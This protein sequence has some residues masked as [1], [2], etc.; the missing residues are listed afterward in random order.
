MSHVRITAT[1]DGRAFVDR[2]IEISCD[3]RVE[4][5]L[6]AAWHDVLGG[7]CMAREIRPGKRAPKGCVTLHAYNGPR[8]TPGDDRAAEAAAKGRVIG[9]FKVVLAGRKRRR[10]PWYG[11]PPPKARARAAGPARTPRSDKKPAEGGKHDS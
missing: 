7:P 10:K 9:R 3:Q 4:V 8:L 1:A 11:P 5:A 6:A 2:H